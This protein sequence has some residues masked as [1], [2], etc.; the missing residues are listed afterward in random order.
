M[1]ISL[2]L[3]AAALPLTAQHD[4]AHMEGMKGMD[5]MD[6]QSMAHE[7]GGPVL[8]P[9]AAPMHMLHF[10]PGRWTLMA[11][12]AA[13]LTSIQQTGPRGHDK[14]AAMN[15]GMLEA[16]HQLGPGTFTIRS[17]LRWDEKADLLT[18]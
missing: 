8:N 18:G 15:W 13:F 16:S 17:M 1:R 10:T 2:L 3:L 7:A 4:M 9:S 6:H 12:A 11:H 5:H 14:F